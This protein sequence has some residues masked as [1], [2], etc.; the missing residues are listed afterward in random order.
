MTKTKWQPIG[1]EHAE[2]MNWVNL[3]DYHQIV[4]PTN[5]E[6][7][8]EALCFGLAGGIGAGYSFCPSVIKH[9][10]GCG[11][12]L[13][14]RHKI[15]STQGDWYRSFADRL[16]LK[17]KI[18]ET[19][20][21]KKAQQLL[22]QELEQDRPVVVFTS[23]H[24]LP[25]LGDLE[26]MFNVGMHSFLVYAIDAKSNLAYGAD[27]GEAPVTM[28]LEQLSLAR[29]SVCSHKNRCLSLLPDQQ[30][31]LATLQQGLVDAISATVQELLHGKMQTFSLPGLVTCAKVMV[32]DKASDGWLRA[33][34]NGLVFDALRNLFASIETAGT[35][36]GLFRKLYAQFLSE[37]GVILENAALQ[38]LA[39]E[40]Q[41]LAAQ[42]TEFAELALTDQI[43]A[44]RQIKKLLRKQTE[45]LQKKGSKGQATIDKT[46]EELRE[47][48]KTI[49]DDFPMVD[50]DLRNHLETLRARLLELHAEETNLATKLS[51]AITR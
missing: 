4:N 28:P 29:A 21:T 33:L 35:G 5:S 45:T 32:N 36:T 18:E 40:Y 10:G 27:I 30:I 50:A 43:K 6:P 3:L 13:V 12:S 25:F 9:G 34:P 8:S 14:G 20:A 38:Q 42:W 37:A 46:T 7:F 51:E 19:T 24:H 31:D 2:S 1:G 47:L 49:R 23:R 15:Y 16:G 22:L 44:F 11:I 39:G 41:K 48:G 26:S 17:L